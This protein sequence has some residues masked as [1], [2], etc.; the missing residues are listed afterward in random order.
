MKRLIVIA[1]AMVGGSAYANPHAMPG[2]LDDV[3]VTPN[4][5]AIAPPILFLD[6]CKGNCT[7]TAGAA[8]DAAA[9]VSAIPCTPGHANCTN[10]ASC[11]CDD[12]TGVFTLHEFKDSNNATSPASDAEWNAIVQC[13]REVYSPY[14]VMV[15]DVK[16]T[17]GGTYNRG[18]VGGL[19]NDFGYPPTIG[20]LGPPSSCSPQS[21][22][23][24]VTFSDA[25]PLM[26]F[27]TQQARIYFLCGVVAQETAHGYG[28]EHEYSFTDNTSSCR[29]PMTYRNDCGGEKFFRGL[30]ANCGEYA[31]RPCVCGAL[32]NSHQRLLTAFGPGTP[33]T[34]APH[35]TIT[36][37]TNGAM[38]GNG[39]AIVAAAGAQRGVEKVE[40]WL[41]NHKW[42][43]VLGAAWG[44]NGQPDPS[45]YNVLMPTNVPDGIIDVVLKAYDDINVET[46]SAIVTVT[47]GAPCATADTCAKGQKCD[48]GKCY[49]DAPTGAL[50]DNCTFNEFCTSGICSGTADKQICT[51]SCVLGSMDACP[52]SYDCIM[53][54][55]SEGICFPTDAGGG[56][57]SA[58]GA[59]WAS[60]GLAAIVLGLV[61]R[62]RRHQRGL[63]AR[64]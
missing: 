4:P 7:I 36:N 32:Q 25:F 1:I 64:A 41:N 2:T 23:S 14:A 18:L 40:L 16:P 21:N 38:I 30:P 47:K 29:S 61:L 49:W 6:R 34:G 57:C 39:V 17:Q 10:G 52:T 20:G 13:V 55:A 43:E 46:D 27:G 58:T 44:A 56:C 5:S 33:I 63:E 15:T 62:R 59:P 45:S 37:P 26:D 54:S 48:A 53:T 31:T 11:Q 24:S 42:A 9:N 51:M 19:S 8:D 60:S 28:L 12:H 22:V 3:R 50:G 35:V